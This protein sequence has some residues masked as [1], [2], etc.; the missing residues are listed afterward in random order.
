MPTNVIMP[1][2]DS[3]TGI[4]NPLQAAI[5]AVGALANRPA[6]VGGQLRIAPTMRLTLSVD[7]RVADGAMAARFLATFATMVA[8]P[9]LS[10]A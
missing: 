7:H 9:R 5:L 1:A 10:D 2:L 8:D 3:F 4:I 6:S